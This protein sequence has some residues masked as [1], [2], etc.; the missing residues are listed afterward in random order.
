VIYI[1]IISVRGLLS[2]LEC[3]KKN[4][5]YVI[6]DILTKSQE[7]EREREGI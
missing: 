5:F 3:R 2:E 4:T 1:Y 6:S 7:R